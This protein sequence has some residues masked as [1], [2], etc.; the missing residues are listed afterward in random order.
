MRFLISIEI[1]SSSIRFPGSAR[2]VR[3]V[4]VR[5]QALNIFASDIFMPN[6]GLSYSIPTCFAPYV[7]VR[8]ARF[9][10]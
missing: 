7:K 2:C 4:V 9:G 6:N 10:K 3:L 8:K 5:K 1:R